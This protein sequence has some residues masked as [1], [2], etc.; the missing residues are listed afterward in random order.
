MAEVLT[1]GGVDRTALIWGDTLKIEQVAGEFSAVC[2]F[3]LN[4]VTSTLAIETRDAVTVVDGGTTLFAG[5]VVDVDTDLLDLAVDGRRLTVLCQDYQI[6]VEEAVIDGQE[7]YSAQADSAII[8]DLFASYRADVDATTYVSTLNASM[9]VTVEDVTLRQA[10]AEI[11]GRTGGRWYV[12]ENKNLHYFDA[13]SNVAA[14]FLSDTPDNATSFPYQHIAVRLKATTIVN[15]VLVVG[16]NV[17]AW[18]EDA[19]SVA[20]YGTRPAV[21]V[22]TAIADATAAN[23]RGD[24]IL[25]KYGY[26]H[27][28]Y[29]VTTRKEGLRAGMDVRLVCGAWGLDDTLTVERLTI[30]WRGNV[31]FYELEIGEGV[32][33]ALTTG[34]TWMDR[35]SRVEGTANS[36]DGIVFDDDAPSAPAFVGG[37]LTT[38]VSLDADGHQIVWIRATWGSVA[39]DDLDHYEIQLADS[40]AFNWPQ[41]QHVQAGDT[42][43]AEWLG[44]QGNV[45]YYARVRAVDWTGN[46][47]AWAPSPPG[48][49]TVTSS[50]DGTPPGTPAGLSVAGAPVGIHAIWDRN[51]E[52]DLSH[53]VLER[54]PDVAGSPGSWS[55]IAS[56]DFNFVIDE[57]FTEANVLDGDEF[58][59]RV[60]ALDTSGNAS[61]YATAAAAAAPSQIANGHLAADIVTARLVGANQII[62]QSANIGNA[63][64]G[65][66]HIDTLTAT[67][68][69]ISTLS[70]ITADMGILTAGEIRVGTG[71]PGVDFTGYRIMSSYLAGYNNDVAQIFINATDGKFYASAGTVWADADGYGVQAGTTPVAFA[72]N[73]AYT[74]KTAAGGTAIGGLAG[75]YNASPYAI[76]HLVL[77]CNSQASIDSA[78]YQPVYVA[79]GQTGTWGAL[80][81]SPNSS[82][83]YISLD[84]VNGTTQYAVFGGVNENCQVFIHDSSNVN[85]TIGLTINQLSNDDEALALKSTDVA[86][87]MT[88]LAETDTYYTVSKVEGTSGG[89]LLRGLKDADGTGAYALNIQG[90]LGENVETAKGTTAKGIVC[91]DMAVKSG[92]TGGAV[93]ADG[94]MVVFRNWGNARFVFDAEG[95]M[96]SDAIIGIGDDWDAWD[97]LA[98]AADLSRLPKAKWS[99]MMKYHAEDFERAGLLTLSTDAQGVQHAFVKHTAMIQFMLCCFREVGQVFEDQRRRIAV[100]EG[101]G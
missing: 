31:R 28:S 67:S 7:V 37:N 39:D 13:E 22:D 101:R 59:Y 94:N 55:V 49:L 89:A 98:L 33:A 96:H 4:D 29:S 82:T 30:R 41:I 54:A 50:A 52:A 46:Y 60:K 65:D 69:T 45:S 2:S 62:T 43:E 83:D 18:R 6:L 88:T 1:I 48:Y 32:A 95:E 100:L 19:A 47:S 16:T 91:F 70:A 25:A 10:L 80:V 56:S 42:R 12:D 84:I 72:A 64:I 79:T 23:E 53:Y 35:I 97:D 81:Y 20:A 15:R 8:A 34:R 11:C 93:N 36:L 14:W 24:A 74:V 21:V 92:T 61:S 5:E 75:A 57:D 87:G 76:S 38:G 73:Q 66:A 86:H 85:M 44:L 71:T 90:V 51:S 78:I 3:K 58:W 77:R 9:D 27:T 40:A 63:I 26:P 17:R 68:L 99:E